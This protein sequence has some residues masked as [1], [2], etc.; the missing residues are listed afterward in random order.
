MH[1]LKLTLTPHWENESV[2]CLD[3]AAYCDAACLPQD[4]AEPMLRYCDHAFNNLVPYPEYDVL[5]MADSCG[6][7]TWQVAKK[8]AFTTMLEEYGYFFDRQPEGELH[9]TLRLY[10]RVLPEGYV[11]SPYM[12]LRAEP[13]GMNGSGMFIFAVPCTEEKLHIT[14]A[15]DLSLLPAGAR[16][17]LSLGEG[18]VEKDMK[19]DGLW[20]V[21]FNI[22]MMQAIETE[23]MG[24]Y[25]FSEPNFDVRSVAEKLLPIYRYEAGHF[26]DAS[27]T[28]RVFLRR[29]PFERSG[30]G[31][32]CP[33]AFISGYSAFGGMEAGKWFNMLLHEMTHTWPSMEDNPVGTGTWFSEGATEYFCTVLPYRG[34]FI[35]AE[36]TAKRLNEKIHERYYNNPYRSMDLMDIPP[37]QWKDRRAQPQPYGRGMLYL[38]NTDCILRREGKGCVEDAFRGHNITSPISVDDWRAFITERLGEKGLRDFEAMCAGSLLIP[39][40]GLFGDEIET[41][42][43]DVEIDGVRME[44]YSWR[45]RQ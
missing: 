7:L 3:V 30:G 11:A 17:I 18:T 6:S 22:G 28:F 40:E 27:C 38:A 4:C 24:I 2:S 1:Q 45:A 23:D 43:D 5:E 44:A 20:Q 34:G 39:E 10:P 16:G 9:W 36:E 15:W 21:L 13:L 8:T 35:S 42:R 31:T 14:L 33:Y 32:A 12:D 29:D 25:W 41:Y 26:G 37:I 19:P